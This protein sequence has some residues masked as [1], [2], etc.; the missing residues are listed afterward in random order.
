[1][2]YAVGLYNGG[3]YSGA[4]AKPIRTNRE[5][6]QRMDEFAREYGRT[7][8]GDPRCQRLQSSFRASA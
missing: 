3:T 8:R 5:I 6:E 2:P 7:E 1:M 4:L